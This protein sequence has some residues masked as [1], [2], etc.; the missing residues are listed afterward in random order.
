MQFNTLLLNSWDEV[1][2][3]TWEHE[4]DLDQYGS[5]VSRYWAGDPVQVG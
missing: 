2:I 5:L 1:T 3:K 4:T